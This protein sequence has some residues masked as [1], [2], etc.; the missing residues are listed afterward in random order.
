MSLDQRE[1]RQARSLQPQ[2]HFLRGCRIPVFHS[3]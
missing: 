1:L 2:G 3:A